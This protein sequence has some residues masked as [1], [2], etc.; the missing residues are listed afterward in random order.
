MAAA[1]AAAAAAAGWLHKLALR[2]WAARFGGA[3]WAICLTV[4]PGNEYKCD[5]VRSIYLSVPVDF[6]E[7]PK[8]EILKASVI[9][10]G[11]WDACRHE[12][13]GFDNQP[14]DAEAYC[15]QPVVQELH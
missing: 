9:D 6:I 14:D 7:R 12:R 5:P 8:C 1:A 11:P 3:W 2:C 10:F 15:C 13:R 4:T